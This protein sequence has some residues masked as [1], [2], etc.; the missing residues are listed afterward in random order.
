VRPLTDKSEGDFLKGLTVPESVEI[1]SIHGSFFFGAANKL[2]EVERFLFKKP[3]VLILEMS[4]VLLLDA[5]GLK[6]LQQIY[7][8]CQDAKIRLVLVG[9]HAQP[10]MVFQNANQY[11]VFGEDNFKGDLREALAELKPEG[12]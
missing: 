1:Y 2:L 3:K 8:R 7:K 4:G 12:V 9:I 5:S 6:I 10:M 11:E